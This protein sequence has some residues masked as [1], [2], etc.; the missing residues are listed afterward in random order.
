[1]VIFSY[2]TPRRNTGRMVLAAQRDGRSDRSVCLGDERC[3]LPPMHRGPA[4]WKSPQN[5][6]T[7]VIVCKPMK[8]QY[9]CLTCCAS[10]VQQSFINGT[11]IGSRSCLQTSGSK[12]ISRCIFVHARHVQE[13][14]VD[15]QFI[16]DSPA[17][18]QREEQQCKLL[19]ADDWINNEYSL[20]L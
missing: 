6:K 11:R 2:T 10:A 14:M 7:S 4:A 5:Q 8:T 20:S 18:Y 15:P 19:A 9:P 3:S 13:H 17:M 12:P 16:C 1:M